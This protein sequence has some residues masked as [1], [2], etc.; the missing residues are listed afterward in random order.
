MSYSA[1][2]SRINPTCFFFLI[3][4]SGSMS[5]PIMGV[6]GNPRKADFVADALNKV[7]QTLVI[8]ASKEEGIRNYYQI[9]GLGYGQEILYPFEPI[10]GS[11]D[12]IWVSDLGSK[13]VRVEERTIKQPDQAGGVVKTQSKFPIWIDPVATGRTPMCEALSRIKPIL[14]TWVDA[15]PNSYPP[16]VINLTDGEA[17][18]ADPRDIAQEIKDLQTN[19]GN[20]LFF[21]LHVSSNQFARTV[22]CPGVDEGLPDQ[23]SKVMF[24]MS[25]QMTDRMI[26]MAKNEYNFQVEP[27]GKAFVYN[28]DIDQ[29][30]ALLDI[31]TRPANMR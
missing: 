25:S 19:D 21:T 9:G 4:Q 14:E 3:D 31:G 29:L 20:V 2:I 13:P 24:E 7:I 16:T 11:Q 26:Q 22:V 5:D 23:P 15:H 8:T 17:T 1:E 30:V 10:F 27:G 28:A 12:L 18:D 6:P